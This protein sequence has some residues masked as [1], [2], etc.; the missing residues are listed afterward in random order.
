MLRNASGQVPDARLDVIGSELTDWAASVPD[1]AAH[2]AWLAIQE[3]LL[4]REPQKVEAFQAL[5]HTLGLHRYEPRLA[6]LIART[7]VG[8]N[9]PNRAEKLLTSFGARPTTN[10]AWVGAAS[11]LVYLQTDQADARSRRLASRERKTLIRP[12][13]RGTYRP[14]TRVRPSAFRV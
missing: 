3:S 2:V 14:V 11:A 12:A 6:V 9:R 4:R 7:M 13:P 5:A 8:Q 1:A 10:Q